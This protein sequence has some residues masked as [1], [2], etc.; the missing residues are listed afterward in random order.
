MLVTEVPKQRRVDMLD[1]LFCPKVQARLF[2]HRD[3]EF[4]QQYANYLHDHGNAR[5]TI[6]EYIWPVEHFCSWLVSERR[7]LHT[8]DERLVRTFLEEHLPNCSCP[9]PAAVSIKNVRPALKHLLNLLHAQCSKVPKASRIDAILEDYRQYLCDVGGLAV[10]T[11][12]NKTD[13]VRRFLEARFG[14]GILRWSALQPHDVRTYVVKYAKS[15]RQASVRTLAGSLRSFLRFLQVRNMSIKSSL[16][17][18]FP[19]FPTGD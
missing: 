17:L 9:R 8:V 10:A 16:M 6:Q 12:K 11:R 7:C 18:R 1:Q 2:A 5:R 13:Y 19:L 4:F 14:N 3:S 15:G